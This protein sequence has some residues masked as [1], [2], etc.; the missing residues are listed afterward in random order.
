[1]V[2]DGGKKLA[3]ARSC[4]DI[5]DMS[6]APLRFKEKDLLR[7]MRAAQKAGGGRGVDILTDGTIRHLPACVFDVVKSSQAAP[8]ERDLGNPW[9]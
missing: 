5:S 8:E 2:D 7:A 1:M 3:L 9:D 6:R 4:R